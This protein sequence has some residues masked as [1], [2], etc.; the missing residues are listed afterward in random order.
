MILPSVVNATLTQVQPEDLSET[1]SSHGG[2]LFILF[3]LA[4]YAL[5]LWD[6]WLNLRLRA[7]E[8]RHLQ[9]IGKLEGYGSVAG[10]TPRSRPDS[11]RS[12]ILSNE[13]GKFPEPPSPL[14]LSPPAPTLDVQNSIP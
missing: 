9:A 14:H 6:K 1:F 7:E 12:S 10:A 5:A 8:N 4:F 11:R 13:L 3:M 2:I